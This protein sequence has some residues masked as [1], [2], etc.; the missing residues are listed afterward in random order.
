MVSME[1]HVTCIMNSVLHTSF[2]GGLV[3]ASLLATMF[4]MLNKRR[5][6][7]GQHLNSFRGIF[8]ITQ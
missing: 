7:L 2:I 1:K 4:S 3:S 8:L 6:R 5:P